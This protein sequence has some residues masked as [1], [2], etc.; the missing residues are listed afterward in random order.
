MERGAHSQNTHMSW[1]DMC[2]LAGAAYVP[3]AS[4]YNARSHNATVFSNASSPTILLLPK[5]NLPYVEEGQ[6]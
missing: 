5:V 4:E 2:E 3:M 1:R 6:I